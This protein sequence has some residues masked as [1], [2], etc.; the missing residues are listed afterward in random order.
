[1]KKIMIIM[2]II[3]SLSFTKVKATCNDTE[4]NDLAERFNAMY[5]ELENGDI[6]FND[7]SRIF[8]S[9]DYSYVIFLYPYSDKLK[10]MVSD[11][12]VNG[13]REVEEDK[14]LEAFSIPSYIHYEAK[15]YSIELY[16]ADN[17]ACKGELL[18]KLDY[19]VPAFNEYRLYDH[20]QNQDNKD[21]DICKLMNNT[22]NMKM[23]EYE[24]IVKKNNEENKIKNMTAKEKL[25][26]YSKKYCLYAIIPMLLISIYYTIKI[27][28][29]KKKVENQ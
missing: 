27:K 2:L 11:T 28:K 7:S 6:V 19:E 17:S 9:N 21:D 25:V 23:T 3:I 15:K 24:T 26:Y 29:Y 18:K 8:Y 4:I 16:G 20:C 13:K 14:L 12:V 10:V 22:S 1:M 5:F